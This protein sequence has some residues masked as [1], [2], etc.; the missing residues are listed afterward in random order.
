MSGDVTRLLEAAAGGSRSAIDELLP[1]VYEE[2]RRMAA[3]QLNSERAEHTLQ[4]T[5]LVHEAYLKLVD[6]R[7]AGGTSRAQFF[8]VA[9]QAM[10]RVLVDHARGRGRVKRGGGRGKTALDEAVVM[11]EERA[12]D[13]VALD[14]AL[15]RLAA[16]D[17]QK[18][19]VVELRFFAGFSAQETADLLGLSL[20]T[21]ER[22]WTMAR[23]W[24][25]GQ[26]SEAAP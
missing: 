22:D 5:A 26:V 24:L 14:E 6:Q 12:E 19:R 2:L 8:G 17:P 11:L 16:I 1:V 25:R 23:A 20:R 10:R 13:L 7:T 4:A 15:G 21:V 3:A 9:A 18:G